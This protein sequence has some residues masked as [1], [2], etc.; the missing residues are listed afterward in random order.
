MT[1]RTTALSWRE[2]F[3]AAFNLFWVQFPEACRD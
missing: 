2:L 3:H 1:F